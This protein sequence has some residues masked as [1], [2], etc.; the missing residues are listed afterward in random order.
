MLTPGASSEPVGL[1]LGVHAA[2]ERRQVAVREEPEGDRRAET[3]GDQEI[4]KD[5]REQNK[6]HDTQPWVPDDLL[7]VAEEDKG[8]GNGER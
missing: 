5:E 6:D 1:L 7:T 8:G 2:L 4:G 3:K